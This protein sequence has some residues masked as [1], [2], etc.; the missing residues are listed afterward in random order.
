MEYL[1]EAEMSMLKAIENLE[2]RLITVRAG[3]ANASMLNGIMVDYCSNGDGD[4]FRSQ[5]FEHKYLGC[6]SN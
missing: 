5:N 6:F 3:R 1:E 2:E 4:G